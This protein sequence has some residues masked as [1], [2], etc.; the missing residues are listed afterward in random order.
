MAQGGVR[1]L[2]VPFQVH[3]M[4]S[5][6]S[7]QEQ[8]R[9][10]VSQQLTEDGVTV[11][12]LPGPGEA[13]VGA[14]DDSGFG[15]FRSLGSTVAA[16]FVI[17][18]SFTLI[19]DRYS[20]D[21]K[22]LETYG[23]EPPQTVFV[24][25]DGVETMLDAV[26]KLARNVGLKVLGLEK[27]ADVLVSGNKRIESEAIKRV[28]TTRSGELYLKRYIRDDVK[29]IFKMGFFGDV[30]VE[31]AD[32]PEGK[33]V[34]FLVEERE[35]V[36]QIRSKGN[37]KFDDEEVKEAL[38]TKAGA[39]LNFNTLKSDVQEIKALYKDKGYHNAQ[40]T[41]DIE[42][43][44]ENQANV[45]FV[46]EEGD[47]IFVKAISFE[48]N[49]AFDDDELKDLMSTTEKGFFSWLTSSGD[50]DR[51]ALE[52]DVLRIT[53]YYHNH[54]YIQARVGEAELQYEENS[55]LISVKVEEGVEY[56][57]G[58]VALEGDLIR[59]EEEL[60]AWIK[61]AS[62]QVFNR[63]VIRE[64]LL[65]L[66]DMY[67]DE[68]YAYADISPRI[69]HRD[70]EHEA[71]ITYVIDKG[72]LVFFEKIIIAGNT[73]TRDKVIRRE[74]AIFEQE[75]FSGR[76][77]K[78][79]TRNLHRL[80]FFEDI[81]VNTTQG[82]APDKMV[83]NIDV[84]EKSTGAF[85]FGGGYSNVDS[86][87]FMASINQRNLFGRGQVL[88][89]QAQLGGR[90]TSYS[91]SFTEP[92]LFDIPL[93]AG[94]DIYNTSRDYDTY[95]KDSVGGTLRA[96]YPVFD[97][98]R[99]FVSFNYDQSTIENLADDASSDIREFEGT[100]TAYTVST[101]IRRDTR[102]RT[103]NA[104][105]GSDNNL[106]LKHAGWPF[107]GDIGYTK[108]VGESGWYF[109]LFWNVT[110]FL[111][112]S[113]GFISGGSGN[114]DTKVPTWERFYLGGMNSVRGYDWR[115][116]SPRDPITGDKIGGN[117]MLLFNVECLFPLIKDAGIKGVLFFDTGNAYDNGEELSLSDLKKSVG[118]GIRW[119]SPMGPIRLEYG[120]ILDSERKGEGGWEFSIGAA[121]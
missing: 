39:I 80:N 33:V 87:F 15:H 36:K 107:S 32:S 3:A 79:G 30:R 106:T 35:T 22:V 75:L 21:T 40:V 25:G 97:Y 110:G 100:S 19:G 49:K 5:M 92:W 95:D 46:I 111:H 89:L 60:S 37:D 71:D 101:T 115:E 9:H 8:I 83:V 50:L 57:V 58:K 112:G 76:R 56:K 59:P 99:V 74:L 11:L 70:E 18:G 12:Q 73:K 62:G 1:V 14:V 38:S 114:S 77:L 20:L 45:V 43:V 66:G 90:T 42:P 117:K 7:L 6:G 98:T 120:Y 44:S 85:S 2:V 31:V 94:I 64:D 91:L 51:E 28:V 116:I 82:S 48:G 17:W 16:D 47:K 4:K 63:E 29:S 96:G 113:M 13:Q 23:E 10:L 61:I 105:V 84:T 65:M 119:Q 103:F 69:D 88:G 109:P 52:Q 121:F 26:R 104:T 102:D 24:E 53:A 108:Y 72:K 27:V 93:S 81:K 41:Y 68:G 86:L 78:R 55:I 34:T 54:G 118:Y 67:S